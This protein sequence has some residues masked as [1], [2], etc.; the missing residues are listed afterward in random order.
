MYCLW[1]QTLPLAHCHFIHFWMT[2]LLF[3]EEDHVGKVEKFFWSLQYIPF[4]SSKTNEQK[5]PCQ[6]AQKSLTDL[7]YPGHSF[8]LSYPKPE[9]I[10]SGSALCKPTA[11]LEDTP[12]SGALTKSWARS[13]K[14][15]LDHYEHQTLE[16]L[17]VIEIRA[18]GLSCPNPCPALPFLILLGLVPA[19][20][21]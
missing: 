16:L 1:L 9:L 15:L 10:L 13:H 18:K 14:E 19:G 2:S 11:F 6:S 12:I 7:D 8:R 3:G 20:L 4:L 5:I 17:R 21:L